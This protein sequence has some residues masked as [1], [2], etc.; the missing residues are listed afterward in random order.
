[1]VPRYDKT[2]YNLLALSRSLLI[3][4]QQNEEEKR[5]KC[6]SA[7]EYGLSCSFVYVCKLT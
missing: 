3:I 7:N 2:Q 6:E 1:M 4:F 5:E